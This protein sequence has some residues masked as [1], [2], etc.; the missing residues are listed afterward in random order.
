M[1]KSFLGFFVLLIL[2]L[3][4]PY[5]G[6]A[7]D[8]PTPPNNADASVIDTR[9][10]DEAAAELQAQ[11]K[12]RPRKPTIE[13]EQQPQKLPA[14]EKQFFVRDIIVQ[15]NELIPDE[16]INSLTKL[17]EGRNLTLSVV[18]DLADK[19]Q[20]QYRYYGYITTI[21]YI[22]PQKLENETLV[23]QV[24]EGRM[25]NLYV[26][27]NFWFSTKQIEKKWLLKEG[28]VFEYKKI[29]KSLR[30]INENPDRTAT[31]ILRP[32][33]KTGYTDVYLKVK[34]HFP[35]HAG[36]QFDNRGV[37][38]TGTM[39]Y[40]FNIQHNN[41]IIP[42]SILLTGTVFGK[43]FG[44]FYNQ[45]LVP[46]SS[47]GTKFIYNFSFSKSAPKKQ[48]SPLDIHG[49][50]FIHSLILQQAVHQGDRVNANAHIGFDFKDSNSQ[51]VGGVL[52]K[53]KLRVLRF[54]FDVTEIDKWG[55]TNL[56][57]D[58]SFGIKG[59]GA[60]G[61]NNPF[62]SR[63]GADPNFFKWN[64]LLLRTLRMPWQTQL[65]LK[66]TY[67]VAS[68]KQY[69]QEQFYLGGA[70]TVRGYPEGDYLADNGILA[71]VEYLIPLF[72]IPK[73]WQLPYSST[74]LRQDI[75]I[76]AF[77]DNGFGGLYGASA[78]EV[79]QRNLMGVGGGGRIRVWKDLF[80]RLEVAQALVQ[81]PLTESTQTQFHFR[82]TTEI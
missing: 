63:P 82:L 10:A 57:Q 52:R 77:F 51:F 74:P 62:S 30:R 11:L 81:Q 37:E 27:D 46:I 70:E 59:L 48:F 65:N 79:S 5:L 75:Q 64:G 71:N 20:Q 19:I 14:L 44:S 4:H 21:V 42:D 54:G 1:K 15:G 26:E 29:A 72:I 73:D 17:Y 38:S 33:D 2:L 6:L 69:P 13:D 25:G 80:A 31:A 78:F 58:F 22:P 35:M 67:Q 60:T 28:S 47:F 40:G 45:Y 50:A 41:F 76:V 23:L 36:F 3:Q 56:T 16:D 66:L 55:A 43:D 9:V 49:T 8:P 12:K 34:D 7:E 24:V 61:N 68:G 39:R 18:R 53:D 32:G